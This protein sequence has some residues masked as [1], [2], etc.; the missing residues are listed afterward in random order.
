MSMLNFKYGLHNAL[1]EYSAATQGTI[2]VTAD[3]Q[4]M[5]IDLPKIQNSEGKEVGGRIRVSQIIT[6][7]NIADWQQLTPPY[8]TESFYYIINANALLKCNMIDGKYEWTQINSTATLDKTV[9]DL[10]VLV[11]KDAESGLRGSV[12][13]NATAIAEIQKF[14]NAQ[15]AKDKAQDEA[16][17]ALVQRAGVIEDNLGDLGQVIGYIGEFTNVEEIATKGVTP[18]T[19]D[20]ALI[21]GNIMKYDGTEWKSYNDLV[22][23]IENLRALYNE[24]KGSVPT[25]SAFAELTADV[26]A[27]KKWKNETVDPTLED[28]ETRIDDLETG[29]EG[30]LETIGDAKGGLVKDIAD[31]A[32]LGQK[33]IDDASAAQSDATKALAD[34]KKANDAIG[35]ASSGLVKDIADN[36]KAAADADTKAQG[37][38]NAINNEATGLAAAHA[39]AKAADDKAGQ[40]VTDAATADAKGQSALNKIG[41]ET[42]GLVKDIADNATAAKDAADAAKAADDKAKAAQDDVD[43]LERIVGNADGGLVKSVNT[44]AAD[45]ATLNTNL[46]NETTAREQA[47]AGLKT[48]LLGDIQAADAMKFISTVSAASG[49]PTEDVA[50]GHTYKAIAEFGAAE[51]VTI[52]FA[53]ADDQVI[54]IGDLLIAQGEEVEG[55]I[56][57]DLQW[58]QIPSG[59]V[60]DY[61]PEMDVEEGVNSATINL[62][63]GAYKDGSNLGS[64][65][66]AGDLG[67]V[68]L[69]GDID[70]AIKVAASGNQV[71]I[72]MAWG[73]F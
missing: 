7:D 68:T 32:A 55:V 49:L 24:L 35:D 70:S 3:E 52:V 1:P 27:L 58:L 67:K 42:G 53:D 47:I 12:A 2:F 10:A 31:A 9:E 43:A 44:N 40:A 50:V 72:S 41:D 61:N 51:G 21:G 48:E 62:T 57:A 64:N 5:Y 15:P 59:Y 16:I 17:A 28:H 46:G 45:I 66:G 37:A 6:L 56:A 19:N 4:A 13:A 39:A 63:S 11:G 8:N 14:V 25:D 30:I 73:T 54:H 23:E 60:A 71:T 34:A 69:Q 26:D 18:V 36:K 33:G 20:V 29:V 22:Q 65:V 38:V